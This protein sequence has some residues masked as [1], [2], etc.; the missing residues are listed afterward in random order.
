MK[1]DINMETTSFLKTVEISELN[2]NSMT[3]NIKDKQVEEIITK[4][5]DLKKKINLLWN[6]IN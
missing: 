2:I 6:K 3:N 4:Y 5:F 1:K